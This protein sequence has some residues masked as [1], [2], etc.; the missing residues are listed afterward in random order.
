MQDLLEMRGHSAG[1]YSELPAPY[2]DHAPLKTT[3][4]IYPEQWMLVH[5]E[6]F[7]KEEG[8]MKKQLKVSTIIIAAVALLLIVAISLFTGYSIHKH[9]SQQIKKGEPTIGGL[10]LKSKDEAIKKC[11]EGGIHADI[12]RELQ[13]FDMTSYQNDFEKY[14]RY[15]LYFSNSNSKSDTTVVF[16]VAILADGSIVDVSRESIDHL[17]SGRPVQ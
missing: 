10:L 1:E 4:Y 13:L 17:D 3:T 16:S 14:L 11:K 6:H 8:I 15:V 9:S 5:Q 12:C 2:S 7:S